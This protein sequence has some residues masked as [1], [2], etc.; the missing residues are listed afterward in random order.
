MNAKHWKPL[1]S[2]CAFLAL[3][4]QLEAIDVKPDQLKQKAGEPI[5]TLDIENQSGVIGAGEYA[6]RKYDISYFR[7]NTGTKDY[8]LQYRSLPADQATENSKVLNDSGSG[9]GML[10]PDPNWYKS[11]FITASIE[12]MSGSDIGCH[13]G[14]VRVLKTG[15]KRVGYDLVFELEQCSIVVRTVAMAGRDEL[16]ISVKVTNYNTEANLV[17]GF[18]GFP[19]GFGGEFDRWVHTASKEISHSGPIGKTTSLDI[20]ED[21]WALLTD[22]NL[23]NGG[24]GQLGLFWAPEK[25][26]K[27]TVI[28]SGNYAILLNYQGRDINPEHRFMVCHF[29]GMSWQ[30]ACK[31]MVELAEEAP[32][33][34]KQALD[35]WD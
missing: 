33:L 20:N 31:R 19:M 24:P 3:V 22:H 16:F 6:G 10:K 12:K 25:V 4:T 23:A 17:T 9:Y 26:E 34:I 27:A 28:H 32:S 8:L 7:I 18:K 13:Q 30:G 15:G 35:G 5:A 21:H 14:E 11:G 2:I 1:V 29:D